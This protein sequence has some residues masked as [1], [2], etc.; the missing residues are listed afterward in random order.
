MSQGAP[1]VRFTE[2]TLG[3]AVPSYK[4]T[5]GVIIMDCEKGEVNTP[6]FVSSEGQLIEKTGKP[7]PKKY[8]LGYYSASNF[9]KESSN[10]WVIRV[11]KD[12]KYSTILVRAVVDPIVEHDEFGYILDKPQVDP[13]IKPN[14]Q[15]SQLE[16]DSY[17]FK[18]YPNTRLVTEYAPVISL[19]DKPET[20]DNIVYINNS[21]PVNVGDVVTFK[22]TTGMTREDTLAYKTY[23]VLRKGVI[24]VRFDYITVQEPLTGISMNTRLQKVDTYDVDTNARVKATQAGTA[25]LYLSVTDPTVVTGETILVGGNSRTIVSDGRERVVS[26]FDSSATLGGPAAGV[27]NGTTNM[28]TLNNHDDQDYTHGLE[29]DF[30]GNLYTVDRLENTNQLYLTSQVQTRY[31]LNQTQS[32]AVA[33]NTVFTVSPTTTLNG[34]FTID[35]VQFTVDTTGDSSVEDACN[36]LSTA[37]NSTPS[38]NSSAQVVGQTVVITVNETGPKEL[39][40]GTVTLNVINTVQGTDVQNQRIE[41]TLDP[42]VYDG[43]QREVRLLVDTTP[44]VFN[45]TFNNKEEALIALESA[46]NG[47]SSSLPVV[48]T[49]NADRVLI[50]SPQVLSIT[51]QVAG[52]VRKSVMTPYIIV[53]QPV[54]SNI[55]ANSVVT[56]R[57]I[58]TADYASLVQT[59]EI[60][61]NSNNRTLRVDNN[62]PVAEGDI[63]SVNGSQFT[64]VSKYTT[65]NNVHSIELD[66][67]YLDQTT[68]RIG[69]QVFK[70][71]LGDWRQR[72]AFL[73]HSASPGEWG[74]R[75][76]VTVRDSRDYP[77]GF[78]VDVYYDGV[79]VESWEVSQSFQKDGYG[80]QMH[81]EEKINNQSQYIRVKMN[82]LLVDEDGNY[83]EPLKTL[84]YVAQPVKKINYTE[85]GRTAETVWDTDNLI[86]IRQE[87]VLNIDVNKPVEVGGKVYNIA[88]IDRSAVGG[89]YDTIILETGT[90]LGMEDKLPMERFL[91]IGTAVKQYI[92]RARKEELTLSN[93]ADGDVVTV[94]IRNTTTLVDE[95]VYSYEVQ[96]GETVDDVAQALVALIDPDRRVRADAVG[97]VITLVSQEEGID[98]A[99][100]LSNNLTK[101]VIQEVARQY[102]NFPVTKVV[103]SILPTVTIGSEVDL[104]DGRY[105]ILDAG[106][107]RLS[108]GDD[109]GYPTLGQYLIAA[110]QLVESNRLDFLIAMDG[111]VTIPTYQRRLA[112]ICEKRM[113]AMAFLSVDYNAQF[114]VESSAGTL[115]YRREANINSSYAAMYTP[116]VRVYDK[117]NDIP[118]WAPPE[119]WAARAAGYVSNSG[120]L[121]YAL[122]GDENAKVL[123]DKLGKVYNDGEMNILYD[124]QINPIRFMTNVGMNIGGQKTLLAHTGPT[125]RINVRMVMIVIL[126]GLREYFNRNDFKF[127]N[128]TT[129]NKYETEGRA[130]L[131]DIKIR[132]GLY[133][134]A[135]FCNTQNNTQQVI[136]NNELIVDI[137]LQ[138]TKIGEFITNRMVITA[139]GANL[140]TIIL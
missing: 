70:V 28:L 108:G 52:S 84:Y 85:V 79:Q 39:L 105:I 43:T 7:N 11:D 20:G 110:D 14:G 59:R 91:P 82:E 26:D 95:R 32:Y 94:K 121:W 35:G 19:I 71:A 68:A 96:P 23:T 81:I 53:N 100:E 102:T 18:Q 50:T 77:N 112:E 49:R 47:V 25:K 111:G 1:K 58:Q 140:T 132:G 21:A 133:D 31:T 92:N 42:S 134:Y 17:E 57:T 114:S 72:D 86:R 109:N 48:A 90:T 97:N 80:R 74:N 54:A 2:R 115:A 78:W 122:A 40:D 136:D 125:S 8:G 56:H 60:V 44:V 13:I 69:D 10:L 67:A 89:P 131:Q 73:I 120:E 83:I 75:I 65:T 135:L 12:Q 119:S 116:W 29:I 46:I 38:T 99:T 15:M 45:G 16:L 106:A 66:S 22:D 24:P 130:F 76:A 87:D 103:G 98:F 62:D 93:V 123:G 27:A 9:L 138:P 129:R 55:P 41:V 126:R 36:T 33:T 61:P 34:D 117:Y 88:R 127:N 139:T 104:T 3:E 4:G 118:V 6:I 101:V 63:F 137:G 51:T 113:D 107:N 37:I 64:V 30:D 5:T 124:N 128:E